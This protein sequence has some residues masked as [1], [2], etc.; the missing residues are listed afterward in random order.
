M[1]GWRWSVCRASSGLGRDKPLRRAGGGGCI[2]IS[3]CVWDQPSQQSERPH[4]STIEMEFHIFSYR[5]KKCSF[6]CTNFLLILIVNA[7]RKFKFMCQQ[8]LV[9]GHSVKKS[10][11]IFKRRCLRQ[12]HLCLRLYYLSSYSSFRVDWIKALRVYFISS[13][14][15]MRNCCDPLRIITI[16]TQQWRPQIFAFILPYVILLVEH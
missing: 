1:Q 3:C 6:C 16:A 12:A 5:N 4:R 10:R 14:R 15:H 2:N 7:I 8:C 9:P 11:Y 13:S